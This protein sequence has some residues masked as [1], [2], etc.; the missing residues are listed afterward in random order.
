M[1]PDYYDNQ[2]K[3][4][5]DGLVGHIGRG[6]RISVAAALFSIYGYRELKE[7]LSGCESFRFIYTEPTFLRAKAEKQQREY[8]IPRMGRE[9]SIGGTDLEIKLKNELRQK[10]VARECAEWIRRKAEFRSYRDTNRAAGGYLVVDGTEP[11]AFQPI[12]GLTTSALGTTPSKQLTMTMGIPGDMAR[13][14]LC[15]F[16]AAWDSGELEDVTQA[17]ID[18]ISTMYRENPPELVYYAAL[19]RIFSEFLEDVS[20]DDLAKE[21]TGFKESKVWNLLYDFQQDAALAIINKLQTYNGCIL[22]D[23]VGLGKTF[24]A[25]AVVK[26]YELLNRNV[27]VLCPKRLSDNWLTY[28]KNYVNNPIAADRLRYDVLYHTDLSRDKGMTAEGNDLEKFNWGAY[29]LVVID[30]SHN[31]RNGADTSS[32]VED[33]T[34]GNRFERL[35]NKVIKDGVETKVLMLSATPVNNRFRDLHNQ[36]KLAYQGDPDAWS[37]KLGLDKPVDQ[38]FRDAQAA[39][40]DWS[41]LPAAERTTT[42]LTDRLDFN[43]F[44]ILDRVTVARSRRHV[45]RYYDVSAIG[46]FPKRLKPISLRPSLAT[47][48]EAGTYSQIADT[49]AS[50]TLAVYLPTVYLHPS[51]A[52]KY[53][54]EHGRPPTS[55]REQGMVKLMSSILLKRLESSVYAFGI[56]LGKIIE[57]IEHNLKVIEDYRAGASGASV[58]G[59]ESFDYEEGDADFTVGTK[60]RFSLEDMDWISWERDMLKDLEALEGIRQL[61]APIDAEHDAKLAEL[62]RVIADKVEN[63]IN[64]GN[65][66]LLIFTAFADT[67]D[68][69]YENIGAYVEGRYGLEVAEVA[70]GSQSAHCSV[71]GVRNDMNEVITCF[72]P[73]SKDRDVAYP[74]LKGKD[75]DVLIATD[76]ISEGQNLQD[77]D[78]V[79]N[80]DIHWNPVRIIQ[81]F[82]RIDRLGSTNA[83]IQLVN[84]WP[85]I[86]LDEYIQLEGRVKGRMALLDASATGEENVL[87]AK[88]NGEMNDLKYRRQQL[89]QLKSEV[90]D[91]E[92]ISGGISI[93][94]FAFDDFRVE[95]QRYAKE[96]P[97]ALENSPA[98]LHAVAP[99]PDELRGDVKPG[100]VFCLKQ[101]DEGNDPRDT[102]PVF[103]YYVV[104][105]SADGGIMTKHTQPKP[106]L[107]IMRA[108]CSGHPEPIAELCH[109]FN[110]ETRDGTRMDAYTDL[111]DDVVAAITGTQQDKGIESLFSLGEVGSGTVMGFNDYSLVCF[112]VLR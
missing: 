36:L 87:E 64:P 80:Y 104:Y 45:Q 112:A 66:K 92:D 46:P 86:A 101:N 51:A 95:L 41:E 33:E 102:N 31:F 56:T 9:S 73:I 85:D 21:G 5:K 62:R 20:V 48:D 25:L 55:G 14:Y 93:T 18:S 83:Q 6:D 37:K 97:D 7:Q 61:I 69:L 108:V 32:K 30:E 4:L 111:L 24:T 90:L 16:N 40:R 109:E 43:F 77:C 96:H 27:L 38:V 17:V 23:S 39:F 72:S 68:Y 82:G 105:V 88:G 103:P 75:I 57:V 1:L 2:N 70:G 3:I 94:D 58:E 50:L 81:R 53:A 15:Q 28:K 47:S 100:V 76:C 49:L 26:Y 29:D 74:R 11:A 35:L 19:Y 52:P 8:Y 63:P 78:C 107:D 65:K 110:R 34:Q 106:A 99:I 59:V 91:L 54:D 71:E 79:I 44:Q 13:Q 42:A 60:S 98:G 10:A 89:Q 67:A 84:F 22:A 12:E